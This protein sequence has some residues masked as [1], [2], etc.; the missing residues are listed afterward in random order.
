LPDSAI[1]DRATMLDRVL[2]T[3]DDDLLVEADQ[4]QQ[5]GVEFAGVIYAH[6]LYVSIGQC[7]KD[8]EL[9]ANASELSDMRNR[10]E[11]LPF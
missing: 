10:V 1:L 5:Y 7:V 11:Y 3:R 9:I 6:Q 4:R 8:L 2:F